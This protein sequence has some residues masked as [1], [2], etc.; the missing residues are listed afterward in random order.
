M[1]ATGARAATNAAADQTLKQQN[2]TVASKYVDTPAGSI[3]ETVTTLKY[4]KLN[5][6]KTQSN[7][8]GDIL[9]S[10]RLSGERVA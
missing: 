9:P 2:T 3:I 10:G 7:S 5:I 1:A 8:D 6:I 4:D